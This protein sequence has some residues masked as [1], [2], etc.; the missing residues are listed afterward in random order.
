MS[1][2]MKATDCN[3]VLWGLVVG[4]VTI[5][6]WYHICFCIPLIPQ[7]KLGHLYWPLSPKSVGG[8]HLEVPQ[9]LHFYTSSLTKA[10]LELS[11][12]IIVWMMSPSVTFSIFLCNSTSSICH[13]CILGQFCHNWA[14][15]CTMCTLYTNNALY[16][17]EKFVTVIDNDVLSQK[18]NITKHMLYNISDSYFNKESHYGQLSCNTLH[19]V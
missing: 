2:G 15:L 11:K 6:A 19:S 3:E 13:A 16:H 4:T 5:P 17:H 7:L 18:L 10:L 12:H 9:M 8:L 14:P 1:S